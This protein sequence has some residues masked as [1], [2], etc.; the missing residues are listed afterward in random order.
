ML[1]IARFGRLQPRQTFVL[2]GNDRAA[3]LATLK[4]NYFNI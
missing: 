3:G 2:I 1:I 4:F